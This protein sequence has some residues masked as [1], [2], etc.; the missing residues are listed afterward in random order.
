MPFGSCRPEIY[1]SSRNMDDVMPNH[2]AVLT[3]E[4][5]LL[6]GEVTGFVVCAKPLRFDKL[7]DAV[8][9][10]FVEVAGANG[11]YVFE[12][13]SDARTLLESISADE[14]LGST[15]HVREVQY[16]PDGGPRDGPRLDPTGHPFQ[17][18]GYIVDKAGQR[19]EWRHSGKLGWR[20]AACVLSPRGVRT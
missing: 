9:T 6:R 13:E 18:R 14:R 2:G 19:S 12:S 17:M 5:A 16:L 10:S 11:Y 20:D 7:P 1:D 3:F 8:A 15:Y 4:G